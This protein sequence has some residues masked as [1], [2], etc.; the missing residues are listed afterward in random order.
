MG[1]YYTNGLKAK[2]TALLN[3]LR[4]AMA[5]Y[6]TLERTHHP[7]KIDQGKFI[8][9]TKRMIALVDAELESEEIEDAEKNGDPR[10]PKYGVAF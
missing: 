2:R 10:T 3:E 9:L 4:Q 1:A 5:R 6:A 8:D 7:S